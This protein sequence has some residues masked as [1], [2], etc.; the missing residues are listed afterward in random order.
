MFEL[1]PSALSGCIEIQPRVIQDL[2]GR[3]VKIFHAPIFQ[4]L[5]LETDF[6]EE[7][8]S[9]SKQGVIRGMHFQVPPYDHAKLVYCVQ[10]EA[11]DVVV[12]LRSGSPTCGKTAMFCLSATQGNMVYI[13]RGFAHG[14]CATSH[15]VT[16][17][18]KTTTVYEP[19]ADSGIAW[20]SIGID[21]PSENPILSERDRSF[22][23]FSNFN[24]P[25]IYES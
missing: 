10:G 22:E 14:F 6:V 15:D 24:S 18:Y 11:L 13:P 16:L 23:T 20:D 9:V 25:F 4:K 5:G 3:F 17:V 1:Y 8:Y 7:Y 12:D 21:W 2:R 19:S